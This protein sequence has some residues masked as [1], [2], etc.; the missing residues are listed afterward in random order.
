MKPHLTFTAAGPVYGLIAGVKSGDIADQIAARQTQLKALLAM[1]YGE[2]G[3][4]FRGM[5]DDLQN[6]FMWACSMIASEVRELTDLLQARQAE[7]RRQS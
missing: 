3:E 1:T 4:V 2:E 7:E 6:G 5:S